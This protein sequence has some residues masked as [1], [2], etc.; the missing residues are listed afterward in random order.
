MFKAF[1]CHDERERVRENN[2]GTPQCKRKMY[3]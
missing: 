2:P 1:Q 3:F